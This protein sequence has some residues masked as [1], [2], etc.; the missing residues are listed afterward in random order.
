MQ[1]DYELIGR[2]I[3]Q[4]RKEMHLT[5]ENLAEKLDVSIGYVSQ[6]ERGVTKINLE[7]LGKIS[8]LFNCDI[9]DFV[10]RS[11]TE[12]DYYKR[13]VKKRELLQLFDNLS[14]Q[15]QRQFLLMIKFYLNNR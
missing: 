7:M 11:N 14:E 12:S 8:N 1:I 10:K 3:K 15:E 6:L 4:K 2:R 5:Q 13:D 9:A